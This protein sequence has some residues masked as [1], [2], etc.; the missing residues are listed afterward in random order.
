M[1]TDDV[2]LGDIVEFVLPNSDKIF[3]GT[4][5]DVS[6]YGDN[7][8]LLVKVSGGQNLYIR[9]CFRMPPEYPHNDEWFISIQM[10]VSIPSKNIDPN[11]EL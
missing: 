8:T 9:S 5:L 11:E 6:G 3:T 7:R 2:W 4:C 1:I 10:L